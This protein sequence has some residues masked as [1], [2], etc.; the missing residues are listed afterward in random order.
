MPQPRDGVSDASRIGIKRF[1][2]RHCVIG[3]IPSIFRQIRCQF[4]NGCTYSVLIMQQCESVCCGYASE[5]SD[6]GMVREC[7]MR[8][9]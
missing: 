1:H 3:H 5:L 4:F 8:G 9:D 6:M 2:C 7:V